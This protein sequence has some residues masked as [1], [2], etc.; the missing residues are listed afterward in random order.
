MRIIILAAGRGERLLPLTLNTPKSLLEVRDGVTVLESQLRNTRVAGIEDVVIVCGYRVEQIEAKIKMYQDEWG[1]RIKVI[2][3]PFFDVSNNLVSLWFARE[4]MN[5]DF[6]IVNGDD[7]FDDK[8]VPGLLA[9]DRGWEICM[10]IDRKPSYD[11]DDMKVTLRGTLVVRVGKD[12][13]STEASGES[14]GMIR[15]IGRGRS[16][17]RDKLDALVR[18]SEGKQVFYLHAFDQLMRAGWPV[19]FHEI[20]PEQWSE[21]DFHPDLEAMRS[22]IRLSADFPVR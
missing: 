17:L 22:K 5:D 2:Y 7:V 6:I 8:V 14:I 13:A 18:T 10:V 3:N 21:I 20:L 4:E 11:Q 15:V 19:N 9:A 12:I 1:M 16:L